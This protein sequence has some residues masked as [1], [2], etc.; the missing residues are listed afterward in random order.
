[1]IKLTEINIDEVFGNDAGEDEQPDFLKDV[2]VES[3][4]YKKSITETER[5]LCIRSRKGAGKSALLHRANLFFQ[6]NETISIQISPTDLY[7]QTETKDPNTLIGEFKKNIARI[8]I[9]EI[10]KKVKIKDDGLKEQAMIIAEQ[11]GFKSHDFISRAARVLQGAAKA[12]LPT[13]VNQKSS[14]RILQ[15]LENENN[16]IYIFIDDIDRAWNPSELYKISSLITAIREIIRESKNINFRISIREDVW[17][18]LERKDEQIDKFR[19]Y[20]KQ[21]IWSYNE[22]IDIIGKRIKRYIML[23]EKNYRSLNLTTGLSCLRIITELSMRWNDDTKDTQEVISMLSRRKPRDAIQ[24]LKGAAEKAKKAGEE[25]IDGKHIYEE[26]K[27]NFSKTKT[28]DLFKEFRSECEEVEILIS[29]FGGNEKKWILTFEET[30]NKIK[31]V[32][33]TEIINIFKRRATDMDCLSFLYRC[34]FVSA[35]EE[36]NKMFYKHIHYEDVPQLVDSSTEAK[37]YQWEIHPTFRPNL[38]NIAP[39]TYHKEM[40]RKK[41]NR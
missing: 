7:N 24:L 34:G 4:I 29:V 15:R 31:R 26:Y 28:L 36:T 2:Y 5:I 17:Q 8:C 6:S 3:E 19:Q 21:L 13:D 9:G 25:K 1:M 40:Q 35:R 11:D 22:L 23:K 16:P 32:N 10:A 27:T 14:Y 12:N 18:Y 41:R 30:I 33:G 20:T 37:N 39:T 38:E